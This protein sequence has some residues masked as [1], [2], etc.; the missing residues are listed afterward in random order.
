MNFII[1]HS[2]PAKNNFI[3]LL[4]EHFPLLASAILDESRDDLIYS[5]VSCLTDYANACLENG[6]FFEFKRAVAFFYFTIEQFD[7]VV[8]DALYL[9]FLGDLEMHGNMLAYQEARAL[10]KPEH[11]RFWAEWRAKYFG[12]TYLVD[13]LPNSSPA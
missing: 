5:Q 11:L 10:F 6:Q 13:Y 2:E 3:Q 4:V 12:E 7:G 1:V 8:E 9:N